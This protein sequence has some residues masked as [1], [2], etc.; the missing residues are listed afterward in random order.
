MPGV[1]TAVAMHVNS[2]GAQVGQQSVK[3]DVGT[4]FT[5]PGKYD[6]PVDGDSGGHHGPSLERLRRS[7]EQTLA[8]GTVF[9]GQGPVASGRDAVTGTITTMSFVKYLREPGEVNI[10]PYAS[11]L[12]LYAVAPIPLDGTGAYDD[13]QWQYTHV[14]F[15]GSSDTK[16]TRKRKIQQ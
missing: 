13:H 15:L 5:N 7:S 1:L 2:G 12:L 14:Q 6:I 11:T 16:R 4:G 8:N 9:L 10:D 3:R